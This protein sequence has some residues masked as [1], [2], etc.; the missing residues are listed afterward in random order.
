M[1]PCRA[2]KNLKPARVWCLD[3]DSVDEARLAASID[4]M[5]DPRFL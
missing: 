1:A 4:E 2:A 3:E 5:A